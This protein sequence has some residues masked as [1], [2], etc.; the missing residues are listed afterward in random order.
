[1]SFTSKTDVVLKDSTFL[2]VHFCIACH[3]SL[4]SFVALQPQNVQKYLIKIYVFQNAF[5][6]NTNKSDGMFPIVMKLDEKKE[7]KGA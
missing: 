6:N 7:C 3:F 5:F 1:M 2:K 4:C